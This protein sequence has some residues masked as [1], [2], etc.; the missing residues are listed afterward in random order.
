[1]LRKELNKMKVFCTKLWN[2][3]AQKVD[4]FT[5]SKATI[6]YYRA[7]D[8]KC[9]GAFII[10][11][12]GGYSILS[13]YEGRGYAE[14]LN[15]N[16]IDAFVVEYSVTPACFPV[17]LLE[18]RRSIRFVR[19]YA[20]E[21]KINPNKIAVMGSSAGGHLAALVSTYRTKPENEFLDE[22]DRENYIPNYQ[23][24][25]YPVINFS[26]LEVAHCGSLQNFIGSNSYN[27]AKTLDPILIADKFTPPAFI[28]HTSDDGSVNV[29]N[30]LLYGAKLRELNIPFEMHIYPNGSHG[31][32]LAEHHPHV[33]DWSNRL[34]KWLEYIKFI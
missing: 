24:L 28:W 13:D 33:I 6:T 10:F 30:S 21:L 2:N 34:V 25:A 29:K 14:F 16:G 1:M 11:P 22:I 15:A 27:I 7:D 20:K 8:K 5:I 12:G 3:V 19:Y 26:N 17:P 32:G 9:D 18:A 31:L 4:D 23:I